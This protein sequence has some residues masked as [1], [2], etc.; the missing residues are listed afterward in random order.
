VPQ[1]PR[2][3]LPGTI[4]RHFLIIMLECYL[5]ET[6]KKVLGQCHYYP[7]PVIGYGALN[8]IYNPGLAKINLGLA[9]LVVSQPEVN[10]KTFYDTRSAL[11]HK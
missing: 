4:S 1:H 11:V 7:N 3:T 2:G 6:Y 8:N 9:I 10:M 5:H